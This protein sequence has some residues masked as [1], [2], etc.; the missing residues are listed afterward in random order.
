[1]TFLPQFDNIYFN[2]VFIAFCAVAFVHLLYVLVIHGRMA[3][4][5]PIP[6][7]ENS[8]LPPVSII[9]AARNESE[10]LYDNLPFIMDQDYPEFEVI[11]VNNQSTDDSAW[12]LVAFQ[13]MH[14]NIRVVEIGK[15]KHLRPGK[16][17]P[18][19]LGIK[20]AKY[21]HFVFTDADCKPSSRNWL[22]WMASG[23]NQKEIVLGYAPFEKEKGFVNRLLRFDAAW[24]GVSYLSMALARMPYMGVGRNMAYS[25]KIFEEVK[26][27]KS[28]YSIPSGDDDLFIQQAAKKRNYTV[29]FNP[30]SYCLSPAAPSFQRWIYQKS[31]HYTTTPR[32]SFFKKIMLGIYPSTLLLMYAL[33][34]ATMFKFDFQIVAGAT[35][36]VVVLTKWWIQ[37]RCLN[38]LN[39][40]GFAKFFPFWDLF[41]AILIPV[42]FYFTERQKKNRW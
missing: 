21:E 6:P 24:I 31:R 2:V 22:K 33:F 34:T 40:K 39:E 41:Y 25:R 8:Q 35:L 27:F 15:N 28:H 29:Q 38:K 1:M 20:A 13:R 37:G 3:F 26:G 18:L 30:E 16:K 17:L 14:P 42:I 19:T 9:I 36:F 7:I 12:L 11:I 10:N 4:H 32:Y 5:K 23:F